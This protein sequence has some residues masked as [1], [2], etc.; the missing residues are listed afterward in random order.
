MYITLCFLRVLVAPKKHRDAHPHN[1]ELPSLLS[2]YS[3]PFTKSL[4]HIL[5]LQATD[6]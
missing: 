6:F 5:P 1:I 4:T 2:H 3:P